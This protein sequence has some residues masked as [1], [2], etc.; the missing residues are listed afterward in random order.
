MFFTSVKPAD[1]LQLLSLCMNEKC[2]MFQAEHHFGVLIRSSLFFVYLGS[3]TIKTVDVLLYFSY[4]K[5]LDA[6]M[7]LINQINLD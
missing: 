2:M 3:S 1:E 6:M 4:I 7:L 5:L